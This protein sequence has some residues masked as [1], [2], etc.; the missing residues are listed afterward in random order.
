[1]H[2][3]N[4]GQ[5]SPGS[6]PPDPSRP[7]DP[8]PRRRERPSAP[9]PRYER[10]Y[11]PPQDP[12][13]PQPPYAPPPPHGDAHHGPHG[14]PHLG[15][16]PTHGQFP[17]DRP[18][19]H[20]P[21]PRPHVPPPPFTQGVPPYQPPPP[22]GAGSVLWALAPLYTCGFATPF[23]MGYAAARARSAWLALSALV[24][25]LGLVLFVTGVAADAPG[26]DDTLEIL[27]VLGST[28]NW[29]GGTV[30]SLIVRKHVF[31]RRDSP[32]DQAVAMA[33]YR[34]ELRQQAREL[35]ERDPALAREL[36]IGR[37]DLPRQ[38]DDGGLVDMNHAPA[39]VIATL[40]GMTAELARRV[41]TAREEVGGFISAE[42]V[43][44][45]VNLPP[46]LNADL[47]ELTIY[48]R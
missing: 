42:D 3:T 46:H 47:V 11:A 9:P 35:A 29:L 45:A 5:G 43:S 33:Q 25:A 28:L 26:G 34:R 7:G 27:A 48:L 10:P 39:E 41:V 13:R 21:E 12:R 23:T 17:V 2:P 14:G 15:Q 30:H 16:N 36:R 37:P 44:I 31:E 22:S 4:G 19:P 40:P 24:Y 6:G 20:R 18:A 32:N 8:G 1:M 38:Y